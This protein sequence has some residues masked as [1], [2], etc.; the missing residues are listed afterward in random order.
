MAVLRGTLSGVTRREWSRNWVRMVEFRGCG[1]RVS[2]RRG[3]NWTRLKVSTPDGCRA[4]RKMG[5]PYPRRAKESAGAINCA[6]TCADVGILATCSPRGQWR[7]PE[8]TDYPCGQPLAFLMVTGRHV[9]RWRARP[10]T[11]ISG[12]IGV[13]A[14]EA[15]AP[16][17]ESVKS[18]E[19]RT[20][21]HGS[22][23]VTHMGSTSRPCAS[24]GALLN[25]AAGF[26]LSSSTRNMTLG[27]R[28]S[29]CP[30]TFA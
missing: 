8:A 12:R 21:T 4:V 14:D 13:P 5:S 9:V 19:V 2:L 24:M 10:A 25:V 15:C 16:A 30:E 3:L 7:V 6:P 23:P 22:N 1:T 26:A 28:S 20:L 27:S 18:Q 11:S 29:Y 17:W